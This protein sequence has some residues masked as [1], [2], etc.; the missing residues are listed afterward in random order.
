LRE[1]LKPN[2]PTESRNLFAAGIHNGAADQSPNSA[3]F[4]SDLRAKSYLDDGVVRNFEEIGRP[5]RDPVEKRG[6][7][8]G[9]RV[10]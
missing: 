4:A 7:R 3:P 10:H 5:A 8:K 9:Y 2:F 1:A 6:N